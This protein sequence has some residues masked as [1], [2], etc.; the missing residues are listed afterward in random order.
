MVVRGGFKN[1]EGKVTAV[2]RKKFVIHIDRI[3]RE[4]A[5]GALLRAWWRGVWDRGWVGGLVAPCRPSLLA[6]ECVRLT[7]SPRPFHLPPQQTI[8]QTT[9]ATVQVGIDASKVQITKLKLN[10][11]RK[12]I[13]D[14]KGRAGAGKGKFSDAEVANM[15]GVD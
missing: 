14:R 1:R 12:E 2:Y 4:K 15:G 8:P 10:K 3:T 6:C 5:N 11:A 13:L 9:G 7:L